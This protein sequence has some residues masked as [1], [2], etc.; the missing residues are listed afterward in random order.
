MTP[1]VSDEA[2]F[3]FV[4][5]LGMFGRKS[6]IGSMRRRVSV[7]SASS[8]RNAYDTNKKKKE[9]ELGGDSS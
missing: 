7:L 2:Q 5:E 9:G 3:R 1:Y 4:S 8:C 6:S